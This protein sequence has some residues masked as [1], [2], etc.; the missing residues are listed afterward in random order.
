[1]AGANV[2]PLLTL[3]RATRV[4]LDR[5]VP[6]DPDHIHDV[7]HVSARGALLAAAADGRALIH[8]I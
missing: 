1:V 6:K 2:A 7:A 3:A 4:D 8:S 5:I